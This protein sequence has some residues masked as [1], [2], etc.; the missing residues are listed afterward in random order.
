MNA[1]DPA[2]TR[3]CDLSPE[4]LDR[5]ARAHVDGFFGEVRG[6][7]EHVRT[8][9]NPLKLAGK[10]PLATAAVLGVAGFAAARLLRRKAR[11]SV[12]AGPEPIRVAEPISRTVGRTLLTGLAGAAATALP[13]LL[14][15]YLRRRGRGG[16]P[17]A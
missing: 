17:E 15:A 7:G 12:A 4:E 2:P 9:W 5:R 8:E 13:E 6:V 3:L 16:D 11:G 14:M 1:T 10:H